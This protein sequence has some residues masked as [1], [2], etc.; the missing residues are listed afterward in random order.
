MMSGLPTVSVI[1]PTYNRASLVS[2]AVKSVMA[3][4]YA[5]PEIIIV[6]DGSSDGTE[7]M[8][9]PFV[10][11][12]NGRI[13]YLRQDNQGVSGAL[14]KGMAL[15][16][17]EWIAFLASDDVWLPEKLEWQFRALRQ[18]GS[19]C[20]ACFTDAKYLNNPAVSITAFERAGKRYDGVIGEVGDAP[21]FIANE[22]HGVYVQTLVCRRDVVGSVGG[23]DPEMRLSEDNDFVLR[24]ACITGFC[25]VNLPLVCIERGVGRPVGLAESRTNAA[26]R[27]WHLEYMYRKWLDM[28]LPLRNDVRKVVLEKLA[29][30]YSERSSWNLI[31]EDHQSARKTMVNSLR[32]RFTAASALKWVLI[33]VAPSIAR[34]EVLRREAKR[35][36]HGVL[37]GSGEAERSSL[38]R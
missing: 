18:F 5:A 16:R 15:A 32:T 13:S 21:K 27:L 24:L 7:Q 9:R 4:T 22:P 38:P 25:F 20:G 35:A 34:N 2:A 12:S 6:D 37:P 3:Q 8:L 17:G 29:A 1:I 23:F 31:C 14:N 19:R 11:G 33:T 30:V 36:T 10:E 26:F 28:D